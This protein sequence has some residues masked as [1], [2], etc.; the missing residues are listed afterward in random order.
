MPPFRV[1][2]DLKYTDNGMQ[3]LLDHHPGVE[4]WHELGCT[5]GTAAKNFTSVS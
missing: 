4:K 3:A 5:V 2:K 1:A